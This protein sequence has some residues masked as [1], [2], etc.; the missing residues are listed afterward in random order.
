MHPGLV[1]VCHG[2]TGAL[3]A[4]AARGGVRPQPRGRRLGWRRTLL[5]RGREAETRK[6]LGKRGDYRLASLGLP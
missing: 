4:L 6:D 2:L 5:G 1:A 3:T